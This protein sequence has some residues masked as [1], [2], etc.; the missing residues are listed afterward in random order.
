MVKTLCGHSA[1]KMRT[2][3]SRDICPHHILLRFSAL[4]I[5]VHLLDSTLDENWWEP[6]P[7][8][9]YLIELE[10]APCPLSAFS[11]PGYI[12]GLKSSGDK[13]WFGKTA[14]EGL[15]S[16]LPKNQTL[17]QVQAGRFN[18]MPKGEL[19]SGSRQ[20]GIEDRGV[21]KLIEDRWMV[22]RTK[23]VR[24]HQGLLW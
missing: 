1:N 13:I 12:L 3:I 15:V 8:K 11:C 23:I 19:W 20:F 22:I 4:V 7:L 5:W 6:P 21:G 2:Y 18:Y 17:I 14:S 24:Q 9:S 16:L 10:L